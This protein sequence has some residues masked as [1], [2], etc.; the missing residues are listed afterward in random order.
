MK[1]KIT[2]LGLFVGFFAFVVFQSG[3]NLTPR[4]AQA[5]NQP[6]PTPHEMDLLT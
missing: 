6:T 3:N 1:K 5:W 4:Q 2:F